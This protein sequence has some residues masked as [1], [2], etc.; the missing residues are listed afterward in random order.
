M[1]GQL[2]FYNLA[3]CPKYLPD[4][5]GSGTER[6]ASE[7]C[8]PTFRGRVH[9]GLSRDL[10]RIGRGQRFSLENETVEPEV[11]D[12]HAILSQSTLKS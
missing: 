1:S 11:D 9:R 6:C 4:E 2:C 10:R 7:Q 8:R 3:I 5:F 12:G